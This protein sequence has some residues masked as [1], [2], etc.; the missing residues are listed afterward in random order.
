MGDKGGETR[1]G[2]SRIT[3]QCLEI[4]P[5]PK[6]QVPLFFNVLSA[7]FGPNAI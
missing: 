7:D 5:R 3:L 4:F 6:K 1:I 2:K